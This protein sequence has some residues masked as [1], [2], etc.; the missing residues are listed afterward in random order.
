MIKNDENKKISSSSSSFFS[1]TVNGVYVVSPNE[2]NNNNNNDDDDDLT[3]KSSFFDIDLNENNK[4]DNNYDIDKNIEN[5]YK[6]N[7]FY[8]FFNYLNKKIFFCKKNNQIS[9]LNFENDDHDDINNNLKKKEIPNISEQ[10]SVSPFRKPILFALYGILGLQTSI[11]DY[12]I[13]MDLMRYGLSLSSISSQQFVINIFWYFKVLPAMI[14][15]MYG[16]NGYHRKPYMIVSNFISSIICFIVVLQNDNINIHVFILLFFL[17]NLFV[18]VSDVNYDAC[19]VEE[20]RKESQINRGKIQ[21]WMWVSRDMGCALGDIFGPLFWFWFGSKGVY[22]G[23]GILSL[24]T[25][26][27]SIFFEDYK[28]INIKNNNNDN[29]NNN[30]SY[31][32]MIKITY[33]KWAEN[34]YLIFETIKNNSLKNFLIYSVISALLPT[35]SIA[36]FYY[37]T[38]PLG[39]TPHDMSALSLI[40]SI[41]KIIGS[42]IY[43]ILRDSNIRKMYIIT[44]IIAIIITIF[45]FILVYPIYLN[46]INDDDDDRI[47]NLNKT[48]LYNKIKQP[49]PFGNDTI[50]LADVIGINR[51]ISLS[52]HSSVW[53][54]MEKLRSAPLLA[55]TSLVCGK[56]VEAGG[57]AAILSILNLSSGLGNIVESITM[58]LFNVDHDKYSNLYILVIISFI[59][60][61]ILLNMSFCC[62]PNFKLSEINNNNDDDNNNILKRPDYDEI[63]NNTNNVTKND[64]LT[65]IDDDYKINEKNI[66]DDDYKIN[67]KNID[68]DYKINEENID[69]H[70]KVNEKG[71]GDDDDNNN[72]NDT[73]NDKI[74]K[75]SLNS[76]S[77]FEKT[78]EF[79]S[80]DFTKK[81]INKY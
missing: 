23:T 47:F 14:S 40:T 52:I 38:G 2:N 42:Y 43:S 3:S 48:E 24:M 7:C 15:D 35:G 18:C 80:M 13:R 53:S 25:F 29:N 39:F 12:S 4:M 81:K 66:D 44:G 16:Y 9:D 61:F 26:F 78:A 28:K 17:Y 1:S 37:L 73:N 21:S 32:V 22:L 6:S 60:S 34:I 56:G 27:L 10:L 49:S 68:N 5:K 65:S 79:Y 20:T 50:I 46:N 64:D 36:L 76:I 45:P 30:K 62:V 57:S 58:S 51:F 19:I 59:S 31:F 77:L 54:I 75:S 41:T 55:I 74:S 72:N 71:I 67:K 69:D 70:Y 63:F 33:K 8:I 11:Y